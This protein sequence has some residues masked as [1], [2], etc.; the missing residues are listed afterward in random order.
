[1][2]NQEQD[3]QDAQELKELHK[4]WS[5]QPVVRTDENRD[6]FECYIDMKIP[7]TAPPAK[8]VNL[9]AGF[10]WCDLDPTNP[11]HLNEIYKFLSLNYVEDSEHRFRF[12]LSEQL[13][14]WALTV[15]NFI[16]DWIFGVR[17]KTG[18]LAGFISGVPM[19]I[20]LNGKVEPWC[21]V[22]FMCVHSHLR[23][24]KMAPV[25]IFE[26]HRRVR[27]HNVYKAVFSGADIPSKPFAKAIYKHRPLNLKKL[28]QVGFYPIA[29]N[30]MA[31]AQKR[32]MVPKL[33]HG[34]VRPF[35][36]EEDTDSLLQLLKETGERFK[37]DVEFTPET[38]HHFFTP[39]DNI[40]YTYVVPGTTGI[41]AMFSFYIM[42]WSVLND[43]RVSEIRA[44]YVWYTATKVVDMNSLIADL[45]YK[46]VNDAKA[47]IAN[48]LTIM[49]L[50]DALTA[51]KFESGN[52]ELEYYSYNFAVPNI[53]D[54]ELRF[55]FI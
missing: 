38:I 53:E 16:K 40:L 35:R 12:L 48:S 43:N 54:S 2:S 20:R 23:K 14:G 24:R 39:R 46:A 15:P 50:K 31:A 33:V 36:P 25:L 49:G 55:L 18:A 29:Q 5:E 4:F 17:T 13:L 32:F 51:N 45:L 27:L 7:V 1:M 47:D 8:P 44:A 6:T 41:T 34:N 11:T 30:R 21:S 10:T 22:N 9:P 3:P 19:N 28:S 42:N 52:K 37:F 26:L